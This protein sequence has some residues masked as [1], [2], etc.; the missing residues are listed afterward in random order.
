MLA[1]ESFL[2]LKFM[3]LK[4]VFFSLSFLTE[5]DRL[6]LSCMAAMQTSDVQETLVSDNSVLKLYVV[7]EMKYILYKQFLN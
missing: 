2:Q 1:G 4:N 7:T 6:T 3:F 5:E